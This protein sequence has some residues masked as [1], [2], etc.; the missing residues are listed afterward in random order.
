MCKCMFFNLPEAAKAAAFD[1]FAPRKYKSLI[2]LLQSLGSEVE[3]TVISSSVIP[4]C[5]SPWKKRGHV[6]Q[7]SITPPHDH[8]RAQKT[9]SDCLPSHS[10]VVGHS[11]EP[12]S[13]VM[14]PAKVEMKKKKMFTSPKRVPLSPP[15]ACQSPCLRISGYD[16]KKGKQRKKMERNK[17]KFKN[18]R[19]QL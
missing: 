16:K 11:R 4:T 1:F 9:S 14:A 7:T 19:A 12:E 18:S 3:G 13:L 5:P 6:E 15:P 10:N 8:P 17:S 2:L